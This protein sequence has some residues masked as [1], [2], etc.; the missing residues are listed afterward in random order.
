MDISQPTFNNHIRA[1]Q[2]KLYRRLF[3]RDA[4]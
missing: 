2:R 1:A 3:E 4:V